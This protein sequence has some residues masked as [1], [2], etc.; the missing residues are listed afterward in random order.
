MMRDAGGCGA[1]IGRQAA[2][3]NPIVIGGRAPVWAY[4]SALRCALRKDRAARVFFFDP[5]QP[6]VLVEIPCSPQPGEFPPNVLALCWDR[7]PDGMHRLT[8]NHTATG[9][10]LPPAVAQ[11]LAAAPWALPVQVPQ[12]VGLSGPSPLWLFGV[13]ARWLHNA[14]VKRISSWDMTMKKF[15]PVWT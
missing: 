15:V 7:L 5:R 6:Q 12:A 10:Y 3:G 4:L 14:G 13:Y 11:K 8:F 9:K 1:A 2:S